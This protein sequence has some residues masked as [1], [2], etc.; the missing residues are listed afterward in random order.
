MQYLTK[1]FNEMK[2]KKW[3]NKDIIK[4]LLDDFI[5]TISEGWG[6]IITP[7]R[8]RTLK[9]EESDVL[10]EIL[11]DDYIF[12]ITENGK[13]YNV[14][15]NSSEIRDQLLNDCGDYLIDD[16][17]IKYLKLIELNV[18]YSLPE[19]SKKENL[20]IGDMVN[21]ACEIIYNITCNINYSTIS[22]L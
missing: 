17:D 21:T 8:V 12:A 6:Y 7:I 22:T 19:I 11:Y 20:T 13:F 4:V 10:M 5:D 2:S 16:V 14:I 3:E 1:L 15:T 18:V 9:I